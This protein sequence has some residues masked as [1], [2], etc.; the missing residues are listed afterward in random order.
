MAHIQYNMKVG[1]VRVLGKTRKEENHQQQQHKS[2][3]YSR[4]KRKII[5]NKYY[6]FAPALSHSLFISGLVNDDLGAASAESVKRR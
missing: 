2:C 6:T 5:K 1:R 4:A 3:S